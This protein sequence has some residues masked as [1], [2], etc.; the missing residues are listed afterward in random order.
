MV[1]K[2]VVFEA[3]AIFIKCGVFFGNFKG[4]GFAVRHKFNSIFN[5]CEMAL[6][7]RFKMTMVAT[8]NCFLLIILGKNGLFDKQ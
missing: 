5:H 3:V 4:L 8:L 2:N 7:S 6:V 1:L